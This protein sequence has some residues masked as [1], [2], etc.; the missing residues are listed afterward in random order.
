[1]SIP[2]PHFPIP[3]IQ[4]LQTHDYPPSNPE[5]EVEH[6]PTSVIN[7]DFSKLDT[8][9]K[10]LGE[11]RQEAEDAYASNN[12][13]DPVPDSAYDDAFTLLETLCN[14]KLSMP[15]VSWAED[16]SLSVGWYPDDG[17][18][19]MGIYGDNLVIYNAFFEEKRQFEGVCELS[20]KPVL[21]G[22]LTTL[23]SILV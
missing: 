7:Q 11:I 2:A 22:F 14:Y 23:E 5:T 15:E 18:V 1:M 20:D 3:N 10:E 8:A 21:S 13:I 4:I 19:T 6:S 9:L 17:M 12:E 16:G